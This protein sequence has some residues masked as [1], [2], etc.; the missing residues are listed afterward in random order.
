MQYDSTLHGHAKSVPGVLKVN[1]FRPIVLR[2][3]YKSQNVTNPPSA[4]FMVQTL[5]PQLFSGI[6][7]KTLSPPQLTALSLCLA[8]AFAAHGQTTKPVNLENVSVTGQLA[9]SRGAQDKQRAAQGVVSVVHADDIGQLP[10]STM[11][12]RHWRACP[13]YRGA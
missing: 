6:P 9:S 2:T 11:P 13:A 4:V 7:M 5:L 8:A 1:T 12:Q 10:V 3:R